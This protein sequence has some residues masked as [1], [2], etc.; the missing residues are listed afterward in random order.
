MAFLS[1]ALVGLAWVIWNELGRGWWTERKAR[2]E[3][4]R[5]TVGVY[6]TRNP[7]GTYTDLERLEDGK[8]DS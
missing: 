3:R 1:G 5:S 8:D 7:D 6:V 2:R 4:G